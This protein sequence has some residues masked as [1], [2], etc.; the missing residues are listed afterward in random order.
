MP[1]MRMLMVAALVLTRTIV[2]GEEMQALVCDRTVRTAAT[3]Y[4]RV[5]QDARG[6]W[7]LVTPDGHGFFAMGCNGPVGMR[8]AWCP[9]LGYAPYTRV[10]TNKYGKDRERWSADTIGRLLGWGFNSFNNLSEHFRFIEI[11]CCS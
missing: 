5:E 10:L 6:V 9:A 4:F 11:F 3:G 1:K 8:G 7:R 2:M